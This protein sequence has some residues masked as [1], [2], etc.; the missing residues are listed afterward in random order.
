M[1]D[2]FPQLIEWLEAGERIALAAVIQTWG[3]SPRPVGARMAI[4]SSGKVYGSVSGGC[5]EAAV[6]QTAAEVLRSGTP[7][8]LHFGVGDETAWEVGLACGGTI[9]VFVKP[10]EREVT[11]AL[12]A[13]LKKPAAVAD[14]MIVRGPPPLLGSEALFAS[15][16][17]LAGDLEPGLERQALEISRQALQEGRSGR[18]PLEGG[19]LL[20]AFVD[21]IP[22]APTLVMVG[23]VHI[24]IALAAIARTLGYRTVIIDPRRVFGSPERFEHADEL[25]EAWPEEA[26]SRMELT[27]GTAISMLTHDPKIDDPALKIALASEAFYVGALGSRSTQ[28][29][30]RLRLL[31]AGL[32]TAQLGRLH[33]P[34]GLDIGAETPEEIA[35][36]IMA[37]VVAAR[38]GREHP[39]ETPA[40]PLPHRT[41]S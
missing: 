30:R 31:E 41:Q 38:R 6:F 27:G 23:G 26:F 33:G 16:R 21:V 40:G 13:A 39:A 8:L 20:E 5:V 25:I 1:R 34:I 4:T 14:L 22:P 19:E 17:K 36:A 35:L 18:Y 29:A 24:A 9:E 12:Q 37:E 10:L 15:D 32:T 3:S 7:Q 11:Y 28:A 2:I